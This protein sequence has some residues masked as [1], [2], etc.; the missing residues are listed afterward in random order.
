MG[1]IP[2]ESNLNYNFDIV[3]YSNYGI[4]IEPPT[5]PPLPPSPLTPLPPALSVTP[6]PIIPEE[7]SDFDNIPMEVSE[8]NFK[9]LTENIAFNRK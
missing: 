3:D 5:P 6:E 2:D 1:Y 4:N 8:I 7:K 9:I